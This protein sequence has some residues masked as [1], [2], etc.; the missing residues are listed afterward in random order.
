M[1]IHIYDIDIDTIDSYVSCSIHLLPMPQ[2]NKVSAAGAKRGPDIQ[3]L[4][5]A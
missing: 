3:Y 2:A 4:P 5:Q 1:D